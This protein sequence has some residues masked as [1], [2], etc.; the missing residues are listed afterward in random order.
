MARNEPQVNLRMSRALKERLERFAGTE[1][2]SLTAEIVAR[3]EQSFDLPEIVGEQN[4]AVAQLVSALQK[5]LADNAQLREDVRALKE[6]FD[7]VTNDLAD[8][9]VRKWFDAEAAAKAGR[10]SK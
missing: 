3:L 9:I 1:K 2:R 4:V 10:D 7:H 6:K 8:A 5:E